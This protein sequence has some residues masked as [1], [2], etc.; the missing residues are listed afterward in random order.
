MCVH[1]HQRECC[2]RSCEGG[3]ESTKLGPRQGL[4]NSHANTHL[5]V[6]LKSEGSKLSITAPEKKDTPL[7][8]KTKSGGHNGRSG[9]S[10]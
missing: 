4:S 8:E 10:F 3:R 2:V 5:A 6:T 1:V 9:A 7:T